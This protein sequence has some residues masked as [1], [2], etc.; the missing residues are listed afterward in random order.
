MFVRIVNLI[1]PVLLCS[2]LLFSQDLVREATFDVSTQISPHDQGHHGM[3]VIAHRGA[4]GYLPEHTLAAYSLAYG[5]G[6]DFIEQDVVLTKDNHPIVL[7]DVHLDTVTDVA[8]RFPD[9]KRDDGRYYAIDLT[10]DEIRELSVH[11]RVDAKTGKAVFPGRFPVGLSAFKIPTLIE[12]IELVVG[13]NRSTGR[14]VGIYPEIKKPRWHREQGKDISAIVLRTLS[15]LGYS[16]SGDQIFLQCFDSIELKRIRED[17]GCKLRLV[18][19]IGSN[20]WAEAEADYDAIVTKEGLDNVREYADG[21]GP[22]IPLILEPKQGEG[23]FVV[24]DLVTNAHEIG[25]VVHPF[26]LRADSLPDYASDIKKLAEM[27][28]EIG[29][30]G[31]FVDHCDQ[32]R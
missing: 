10:L 12:A 26:T 27:L 13:L 7:H 1:L 31:F 6:A 16:E 5:M 32:V 21:I 2:E 30:D 8:T 9:R 11:E 4:S 3:V 15:D 25:L 29:V 28:Q 18:Q 22:W 14:S 19:L 24:T 17:L 23:E 20:D